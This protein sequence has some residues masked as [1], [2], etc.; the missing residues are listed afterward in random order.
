MK[1]KW[2]VLIAS[3]IIVYLIAGIGSIFTSKSIAS[4]WYKSIK[5]GITPPS[6]V[7]PIVWN[8]LFFLIAL[9]LY[10]AWINAKKEKLKIAVVFGINLVLNALWSLL[11]FKLQN[12]FYAFV[13]LILILASII[14]MIFITYRIN[15]TSAYLLIPYLLWVSFAGILN[16]LMIK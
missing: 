11:F 12:P 3:L 6:Y 14:A 2:G 7:F 13:D 16:Y 8:L 10:F 1:I 5:P 4:E 15:K 9:S